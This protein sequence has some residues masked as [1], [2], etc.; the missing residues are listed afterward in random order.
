LRHHVGRLEIEGRFGK[1][2]KRFEL[3]DIIGRR[4]V[5]SLVT[6]ITPSFG[7]I[8][9]P[10]GAN[11]ALPARSGSNV[12]DNQMRS[13]RDDHSIFILDLLEDFSPLSLDAVAAGTRTRGADLAPSIARRKSRQTTN[14]IATHPIT[15][16]AI[17]RTIKPVIEQ[18]PADPA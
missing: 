9:E 15:S 16:T 7:P 17:A 14:N 1:G 3:A 4:R 18:G 11:T 2:R 10:S 13:I 8:T 12:I 6:R 5:A